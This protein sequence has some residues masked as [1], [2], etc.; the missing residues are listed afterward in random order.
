M[1]PLVFSLALYNVL[2]GSVITSVADGPWPYSEEV[3]RLILCFFNRLRGTVLG[4][5]EK[6]NGSSVPLL[7]GSIES[8][9]SVLVVG[10][11]FLER[12]RRVGTGE[13]GGAILVPVL[14]R[15]EVDVLGEAAKRGLWPTLSPFTEIEETT[16]IDTSPSK[17]ISIGASRP[18]LQ[19]YS[20]KV[21]AQKVA[22]FA[23]H[24]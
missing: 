19:Q 16:S 22:G 23:R 3:P 15:I 7:A 1:T 10:Q 20:P 12:A 14:G 21:V 6:M 24:R 18:A 2:R 8:Q 9:L 13:T 5:E 4:C 11:L 17:S